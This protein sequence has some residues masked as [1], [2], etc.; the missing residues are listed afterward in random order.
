[1]NAWS[2]G[3]GHLE[4]TQPYPV[5]PEWVKER[6]CNVNPHLLRPPSAECLE[7]ANK[8]E[9]LT[10]VTLDYCAA[11][12]EPADCCNTGMLAYHL[13]GSLFNIVSKKNT[14]VKTCKT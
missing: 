6:D 4:E 2:Q 14:C 13:Y 10:K 12:T 8:A 1:M 9:V 11:Q 7:S 5:S 3:R